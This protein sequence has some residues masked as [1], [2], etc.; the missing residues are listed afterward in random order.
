[1]DARPVRLHGAA[2]NE[3]LGHCVRGFADE[4]GGVR[5]SCSQAQ[6]EDFV[7]GCGRDERNGRRHL[8]CLLET[9]D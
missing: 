9:G 6:R 7:G 1:M 5:I 3:V 4:P 2:V 8:L